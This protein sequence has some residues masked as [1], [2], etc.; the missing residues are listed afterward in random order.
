MN[1]PAQGVLVNAISPIVD[2]SMLTV[3]DHESMIMKLELML[4]RLHSIVM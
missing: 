2:G 4:I 1:V 3:T